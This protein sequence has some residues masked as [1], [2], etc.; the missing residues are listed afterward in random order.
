MV[1]RKG[2]G[3]FFKTVAEYY[4]GQ[5]EDINLLL[6]AE[7]GIVHHHSGLTEPGA[8]FPAM[9]EEELL[10][11]LH[12]QENALTE[13]GIRHLRNLTAGMRGL[14]AG[15]GRGGSSILIN[16]RFGCRLDGV[17]LSPYQADFANKLVQEMGVDE[18][19][20]HQANMMA[21]PF[22][23]NCFDFVW[24][25]ESTEHAPDLGEMFA[26]FG[27][28]AK[29]GAKLV[30]ITG[31]GNP[32][33]PEGQRFI[34]AINEWY[35]IQIHPAQ[36]YLDAAQRTGWELIE[37]EDLTPETI[38]YWDL[39]T[40]SNHRTGVEKFNAAYKSGA[41]EYRLFSFQKID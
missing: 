30:I 35:R 7:D 12:Q 24:A 21:L 25:V 11:E 37:S 19:R 14:D 17:T 15:C 10:R 29:P 32:E 23:D 36:E 4:D 2:E 40:R 16:Q 5:Q 28:V 27:R 39:R 38:P 20:F 9:T 6:A 41:G 1:D 18:L 22:K 13:R 33:H 3:G 31:C 8:V 26:E 34:E